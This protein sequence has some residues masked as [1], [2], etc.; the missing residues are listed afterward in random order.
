MR[1]VGPVFPFQYQPEHQGCAEAGEGIDLPF[2]CRE[3]EGVAPGVGKGSDGAGSHNHDIFGKRQLSL[4]GIADDEPAREMGDCP[5]KQQ[6]CQRRQKTAHRVD[7]HRD[8][9]GIGGKIGE[10][11][12]C[13]HEDRVARR[14]T[15]FKFVCLDDKLAA[16]P[17]R[18]GGL[19]SE[20]IGDEGDGEYYPSRHIVDQVIFSGNHSSKPTRFN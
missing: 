1:S 14:V 18:R 11:A 19:E 17:I 8:A 5:E 15:H 6:D 2:H 9:P 3:P 4:L 12:R 16:V 20:P 13:Q 10:E 7:H